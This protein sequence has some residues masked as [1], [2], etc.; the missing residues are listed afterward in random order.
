MV[1]LHIKLL[2]A[3]TGVARLVLRLYGENS[4]LALKPLKYTTRNRCMLGIISVGTRKRDICACNIFPRLIILHSSSLFE[5]FKFF[6]FF[7]AYSLYCSTLTFPEGFPGQVFFT[8]RERFGPC[9]PQSL[10]SGTALSSLSS[11]RQLA[12]IQDNRNVSLVTN[13]FAVVN[14]VTLHLRQAPQYFQCESFSESCTRYLT[15][16]V[17][18]LRFDL[19]AFA[20]FKAFGTRSSFVIVFLVMNSFQNQYQQKHCCYLLQRKYRLSQPSR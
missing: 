9:R 19:N 7:V 6:F 2:P 11:S 10:I 14:D 18:S 8:L 5:T 12:V 3:V 16:I 1:L 13:I 17:Y 4:W 15:C 20:L